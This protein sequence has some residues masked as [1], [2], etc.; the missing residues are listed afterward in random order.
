MTECRKATHATIDLAA[1]GAR[2][3]A[4]ELN[5]R[6]EYAADL[7]AY[8]CR[9]HRG[10]H[11]TR[12]ASWDGVPNR[13]VYAAKPLRL[14]EWAM[15]E[16]ARIERIELEVLRGNYATREE[17]VAALRYEALPPYL[18]KGGE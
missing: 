15:G 18:R 7:F 17:A 9:E 11:T 14:Q 12:R 6:G 3:F 13:R 10:W 1:V 16:T 5:R 4:L 2:E 8:R